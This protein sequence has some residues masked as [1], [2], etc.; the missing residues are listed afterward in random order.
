MGSRS[1]R[2][3]TTLCTDARDADLID[4]QARP[5]APFSPTKTPVSTRD[6]TLSSAKK[7]FPSVRW[8]NGSFSGA[9]SLLFPISAAAILPRL[10]V[11]VDPREV[12]CN[13][14]Y[15]PNYDYNS[16]R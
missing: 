3:A 8:I 9:R 11:V 6:R 10:S 4:R 7:G 13:R 12:E 14:F 16:G 2:S 1:M 5:V 15:Q